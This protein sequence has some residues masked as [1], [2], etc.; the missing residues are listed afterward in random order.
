MDLNEAE[1]AFLRGM[2]AITLDEQGREIF[3]GL[4]PDES[5]EYLGLSRR[6]EQGE[7]MSAN[8]RYLELHQ[9]HEAERERIVAGEAPLDRAP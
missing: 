4:T 1:Q 8:P 2:R 5:V 6:N 3:V 7:D 9:R